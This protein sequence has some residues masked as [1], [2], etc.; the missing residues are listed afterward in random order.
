MK[1]LIKNEW[2]QRQRDSRLKWLLI[3]LLLLWMSISIIIPR[4]SANVAENIYPLTTNYAFKKQVAQSINK[5]L[6][7]HNSKGER[8]SKI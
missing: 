5:S 1:N 3:F 2:L 4:I 8:A 6:D 7:R